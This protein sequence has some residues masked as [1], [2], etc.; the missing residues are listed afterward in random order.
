MQ[1]KKKIKKIIIHIH[2][3]TTFIFPQLHELIYKPLFVNKN[4]ILI[5]SK[6]TTKGSFC[7]R[8]PITLA[9]T[10]FT[11]CLLSLETTPCPVTE[12]NATFA[13]CCWRLGVHR[14][15]SKLFCSACSYGL[16]FTQIGLPKLHGKFRH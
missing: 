10:V 2:H 15:V 3:K 12:Q 14:S 4:K 5:G 8:M 16:A 6:G 7:P 9:P 1:C 13:P 11:Q